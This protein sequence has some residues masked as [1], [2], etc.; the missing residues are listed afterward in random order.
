[1][2]SKLESGLQ[3]YEDSSIKDK[4]KKIDRHEENLIESNAATNHK[5]EENDPDGFQDFLKKFSDGLVG[6]V[7]RYNDPNFND[8][9][10]NL[11]NIAETSYAEFIS[12]RISDKKFQGTM[13]LVKDELEALIKIFDP[14]SPMRAVTSKE[15]AYRAYIENKRFSY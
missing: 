3:I 4:N 13:Q 9:A 8:E 6:L 14:E 15:Q 12:G 7:H 1:M 11:I 2:S 5:E 10:N